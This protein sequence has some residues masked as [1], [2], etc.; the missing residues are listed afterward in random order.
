[1]D[2]DIT[3]TRQAEEKIRKMQAEQQQEIFRVTLASQ[4]EERRRISES[5]HNGLGQLLYAIKISMAHLTERQA[6]S[7]PEDFTEAKRYTEKL[8]MDSIAE[9]RRISHEL[10]PSILEEFGLKAAVQDVCQQLSKGIRFKCAI[11]EPYRRID[12]YMQL[13]VFRTVQELMLNVVKHSQATEARTEISIDESQVFI[14]VQDNGRGIGMPNDNEGIGLA[15]IRSK[16]ELLNGQVLISPRG[17][18]GTT[19]TV[20]IPLSPGS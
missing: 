13:A 4:E 14:C 10:M 15:S 5:L 2:M 16:V 12:S 17:T 3:A 18:S 11:K 9:C 8:L 6:V 19:V 1:V 7:K 20:T